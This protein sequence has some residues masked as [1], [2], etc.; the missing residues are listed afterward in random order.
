MKVVGG[1]GENPGTDVGDFEVDPENT[2]I[3]DYEAKGY[4]Q[5]GN[6]YWILDYG[7]A[8]D[9]DSEAVEYTFASN[10]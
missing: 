4:N 2:T 10:S 5:N 9:F 7:D 1:G 8:T 6:N 3:E